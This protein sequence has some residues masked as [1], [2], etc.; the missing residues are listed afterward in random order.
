MLVILFISILFGGIAAD[1]TGFGFLFWVITAL[2]FLCGLFASQKIKFF[3]LK[4]GSVQMREAER[5]MKIQNKNDRY[6][7]KFSNI[8]FKHRRYLRKINDRSVAL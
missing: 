7:T 5:E 4:T 8:G 1:L 2:A 3:K 6:F